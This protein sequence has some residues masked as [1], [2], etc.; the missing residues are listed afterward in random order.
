MTDQSVIVNRPR[1]AD[2]HIAVIL[3]WLPTSATA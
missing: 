1:R 2:F 3:D